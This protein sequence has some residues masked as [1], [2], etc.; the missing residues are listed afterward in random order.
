M[1]LHNFKRC[2]ALLCA[3]AFMASLSACFSAGDDP[4]T[5]TGGTTTS[6]STQSTT[7]PVETTSPAETT[8]PI[9]PPET[10]SPETTEPSTEAT[11]APTTEPE[12]VSLLGTVTAGELRIRAKASTNSDIV[13]SLLRGA[14][15]EITETTVVK[16][17]TWGRVEKGWISLDYV[18][19]D[20]EETEV[21]GS[22]IV[23]TVTTNGLRIRSKASTDS[24]VLGELTEGQRLGLDKFTHYGNDLWGHFSQGWVSMNY[25]DLETG[26]EAGGK[27]TGVVTANELRVR[28]GPGVDKDIVTTLSK[29]KKVTISEFYTIGGDVWGN[30]GQGWLSLEYVEFDCG[31][32][33]KSGTNIKAVQ[34][35]GGVV[36]SWM[37]ISPEYLQNHTPKVS[38]LLLASDGSFYFGSSEYTYSSSKGW[39]GASG[40]AGCYGTYTYK[41][42]TLTTVTSSDDYE[43][44]VNKYD[45]PITDKVTVTVSGNILTIQD[46]DKSYFLMRTSSV[47]EYVTEMIRRNPGNIDSAILGTWEHVTKSDHGWQPGGH[48]IFNSDNTFTLTVTEYTYDSA[49]GW[50][51]TPGS[52]KTYKGVYIFGGSHLSLLYQT[53]TNESDGKTAKSEHLTYISDIQISGDTMTGSGA[54]YM[55]NFMP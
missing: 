48:F 47:Y 29:G 20:G 24:K 54:T 17:V 30:N 18:R 3:I 2:A 39:Y 19:L 33:L 25:I 22:G 52:T 14:R 12:K 34:P 5:S 45:K 26:F 49:S 13:G 6:E 11:T 46:G 41:G 32:V 23:G 15:V 40:G 36:G 35:T 27:L 9:V 37:Y 21:I 53:V 16:G 43:G 8:G 1:I 44:I 42:T 7:G 50:L 4:E 51:P 55:K 28:S 31:I 10:Q 38:T